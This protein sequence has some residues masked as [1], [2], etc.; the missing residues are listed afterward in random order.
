MKPSYIFESVTHTDFSDAYMIGL[1]MDEE[2][3]EFTLAFRDAQ[4]EQEA[5]KVRLERDAKLLKVRDWLERHR[6]EEELGIELTIDTTALELLQT[7]QDLRDVPQQDGFPYSVEWPS[8]PSLY[9]AP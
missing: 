1:G 6:D 3:R 8:L 4:R 9:L 7:I 2:Q 5:T